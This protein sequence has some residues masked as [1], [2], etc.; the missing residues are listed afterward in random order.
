MQAIKPYINEEYCIFIHCNPGLKLIQHSGLRAIRV[1]H[2][3]IKIV[4]ECRLQNLS[5][6]RFLHP[7]FFIEIQLVQ[8]APGSILLFC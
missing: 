2:C 8:S 3:D 5:A 7:I 4:P 1:E 6:S